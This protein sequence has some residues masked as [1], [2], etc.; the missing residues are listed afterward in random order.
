MKLPPL[1]PLLVHFPIAFYFLELLLLLFLVAKKD[2]DYHRF[3]LFSI[4]LGFL[5]MLAAMAAGLFDAGGLSNALAHKKVRLHFLSADTL[6][7]FYAARAL[8]WRFG[9][10]AQTKYKWFL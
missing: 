5:F 9:N 4:R 1:H 3:A 6:F 2:E 7:L 10:A 8:Y